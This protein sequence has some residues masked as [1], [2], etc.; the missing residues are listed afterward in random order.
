MNWSKKR[1]LVTGGAGFLGS[2]LCGR[3]KGLNAEIA[4]LDDLSTGDQGL[5]N[6]CADQF[7]LGKVTSENLSKVPDVDLVYHLG[8]PSSIILFDK[9][10][11]AL[12]DT[13]D[14]MRAVLDYCSST[15][16]KKLVY[17]TSSSVYGNS[18]LPQSEEIPTRPVNEY[19]VAKLSCEHLA[20]VHSDVPSVGLR[21]FAGY[22]PGES[23]KVGFCSVIGMFI[24]NIRANQSPL[25]FGSGNQTR[26]FV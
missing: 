25:V 26:D 7:F 5:L 13:V 10:R 14:G 9:N 18:G 6:N 11:D 24:E 21:I 8:A 17:A 1:V 20:R 23:K 19:G 2:S 3:L 16:V 12:K 15:G 4:V 22:G